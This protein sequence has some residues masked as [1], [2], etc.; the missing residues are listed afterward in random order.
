MNKENY[1]TK[2]LKFCKENKIE[3]GLAIKIDSFIK[4]INTEEI[5]YDEDN[6]VSNEELS[7]CC[8]AH[9]RYGRCFDCKE[10]I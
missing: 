9:I 10:N 2:F 5:E 6:E 8:G 4:K 1:K 7:K 3:L